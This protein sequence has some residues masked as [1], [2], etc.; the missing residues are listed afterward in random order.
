MGEYEYQIE[1]ITFRCDIFRVLSSELARS[2]TVDETRNLIILTKDMDLVDGL[3]EMQRKSEGA[4][5]K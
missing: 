5:S 2:C 1:K 4:S 3:R